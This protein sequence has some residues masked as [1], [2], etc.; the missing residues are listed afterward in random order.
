MKKILF[1]GAGNIAQ[2]IISGL[3]LSGFDKKNILFIDRNNNNNEV[4]KKIGI[5]EYSV[6]QKNEIGF[7]VLA[8]KP[9]DALSAFSEIC[10]NFKKAKIISL[11]AGIRSRQ[12]MLDS[13]DVELIR[14]MPNTSSK[15][16]KGITALFNISATKSTFS[17]AKKIFKK[18]GI[19]LELDKENKMD[20]FTGLIGSGPA[21]FF[22]LLKAY[23]KR[24][25]KLCN[26]DKKMTKEI[27][28][29]FIEGVGMSAKGSLHLDELIS[30]VASKKGTTEAGLNSF[31]STKILN[32]FD[33]GIIAAIKRSKEISNES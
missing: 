18:V 7:V 25:M 4:L 13:S 30:A 15:F 21:Y 27:I 23:E 3:T 33:E 24:I 16:N 32:S 11:V 17:K 12:Y 20:D 2:A 26:G 5:K 28:G 22:Y 29:N 1:F 14:A 10:S 6:K 9:K 19:I 31:K 8:V